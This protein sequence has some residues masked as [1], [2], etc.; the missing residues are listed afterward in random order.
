M[1][2]RKSCG[3]QESPGLQRIHQ[4][5]FPEFLEPFKFF[6]QGRISMKSENFVFFVHAFLW[7]NFL[8]LVVET[9][10]SVLELS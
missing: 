8:A 9:W 5:I 6:V 4:Q 1:Y 10:E 2:K 3:R 7:Q